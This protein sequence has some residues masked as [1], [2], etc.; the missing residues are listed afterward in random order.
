MSDELRL[1]QQRIERLESSVGEI[2]D[3]LTHC[4]QVASYP[5][6]AIALAR[7]VAE[8]LV[9]RILENIGI[10]PPAMLDACLRE[11]E[12][13]EV[14]SRGL[15]P[16][17]IITLLHMVRVMGNK[18]THD[19]MRIRSTE[20][21]VYLVLQ[22]LLRV[23]EWYFSEF[24][25]GPKLTP[26]N[27]ESPPNR[28]SGQDVQQATS[29]TSRPRAN[30]RHLLDHSSTRTGPISV[31]RV[32]DLDRWPYEGIESTV[33]GNLDD[34][35]HLITSLRTGTKYRCVPFG[36]NQA[37][38]WGLL[39]HNINGGKTED[40]NGNALISTNV[41]LPDELWIQVDYKLFHSTRRHDDVFITS[42]RNNLMSGQCAPPQLWGKEQA[43]QIEVG[44]LNDPWFEW[45]EMGT[46]PSGEVTYAF[47]SSVSQLQYI[48]AH[49]IPEGVDYQLVLASIVDLRAYRQ[50]PTYRE[51]LKNF[52][53]VKEWFL[54]C[55]GEDGA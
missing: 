48:N 32:V 4:L 7:G 47:A 35:I 21:D 20:S 27:I 37:I 50:P 34:P 15:V 25:R 38:D 23:I 49:T 39:S 51:L 43:V 8:S 11:L 33:I 41:R 36:S 30:A 6:D 44:S 3:R 10:K 2:R 1:L 31:F 18:A 28:G 29:A 52:D 17:E 16:S 5:S 14:M 54:S 40:A 9:K 55:G 46:P 12:K 45:Y 24:E 26:Y 22:S 19:V 13:P 53:L 42:F